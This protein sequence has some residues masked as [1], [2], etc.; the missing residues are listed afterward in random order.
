VISQVCAGPKDLTSKISERFTALRRRY[1]ERAG[2]SAKDLIEIGHI[3]W[4]GIA[5]IFGLADFPVVP[6]E[7]R[8]PIERMKPVAAGISS[9][10][11]F[12]GFIRL[13]HGT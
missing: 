4:R 9:T 8:I 5:P 2:A 10:H 13:G 1:D 6:K 11:F 3:I 12:G 7:F